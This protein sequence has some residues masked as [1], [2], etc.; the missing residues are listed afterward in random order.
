MT[1]V[2][3][4]LCDIDVWTVQPPKHV[5]VGVFRCIISLRYYKIRGLNCDRCSTSLA[6][7]VYLLYQLKWTHQK[8]SSPVLDSLR[9]V[10][11][12][13][14]P[15]EAINSG[16]KSFLI[17]SGMAV[18]IKAMR[19]PSKFWSFNTLNCINHSS[20]HL[21]NTRDSLVYGVW[22]DANISIWHFATLRI[23]TR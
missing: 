9:S 23:E 18:Q 14:P 1:L 7:I 3:D 11:S 21:Q 5:G 6:W 12:S 8:S 16:N 19:E 13:D 22:R 4:H 15:K 2:R 20:S 10:M 17:S